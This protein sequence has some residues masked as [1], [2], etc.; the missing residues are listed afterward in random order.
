METTLINYIRDKQTKQLR[1][2][3]V[4]IRENDEIFYG[5]SLHNPVDKWDRKEG[6]KKAIARARASE[7]KL[8]KVEERLEMVMNGFKHIQ[9]RALKYFKDLPKENVELEIVM[10]QS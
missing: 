6:I 10:E 9:K 1:G 2:T 8:P 4:A 5:Y 3:V 7:Y